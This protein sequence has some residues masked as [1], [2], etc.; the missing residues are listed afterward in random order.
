[1][2]RFLVKLSFLVVLLAGLFY[3]AMHHAQTDAT[4]PRSIE[5]P[6]G[7]PQLEWQL[8]SNGRPHGPRYEYHS[9]GRL[10]AIT[11]FW[12]GELDHFEYVDDR[13]EVL[14]E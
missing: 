12:H 7:T 13:I 2:L 6:D 8:D 5:W 10:R 11:H 1:M 4:S 9:D 14:D 3:G